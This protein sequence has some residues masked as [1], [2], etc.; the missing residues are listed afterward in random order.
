MELLGV[1]TNPWGD[2]AQQ[3]RRFST[4][5]PPPTR[6]SPCQPIPLSA[7]PHPRTIGIWDDGV[8]GPLS[9]VGVW[10]RGQTWCVRWVTREAAGRR[11]CNPPPQVGGCHSGVWGDN[12]HPIRLCVGVGPRAE[13][14]AEGAVGGDRRVDGVV[15]RGAVDE[16]EGRVGRP[17]GGRSVPKTQEGGHFTSEEEIT[18]MWGN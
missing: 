11:R 12:R 2:P 15:R 18:K 3:P 5:P 9:P 17:R 14:E 13:E 10:V 7:D 6:L 8:Q 1:T 16:N 4:T